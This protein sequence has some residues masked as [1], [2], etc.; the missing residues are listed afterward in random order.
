MFTAKIG[1]TNNYLDKVL[2]RNLKIYVD[3]KEVYSITVNTGG[4]LQEVS[5][6]LSHASK[7]GFEISGASDT[8]GTHQYD[9]GIFNGEF[10]K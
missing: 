10:I 3:D 1:P 6:D 4:L 5:I 7:I 8:K 9:L 2:V